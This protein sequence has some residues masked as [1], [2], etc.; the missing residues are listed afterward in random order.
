MNVLYTAEALATGDGRS[1]KV[2][3]SDG[4]LA[5]QLAAGVVG[6]FTQ[7]HASSPIRHAQARPARSSA[8]FVLME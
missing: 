2:I 7:P 8:V 5:A 6:Y 3:T 1:G 4:L